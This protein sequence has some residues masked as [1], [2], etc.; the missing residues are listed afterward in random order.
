MK[1][2]LNRDYFYFQEELLKFDRGEYNDQV[3]SFAWLGQLINEMV[4][5]P[6]L[7]ELEELEYQRELKETQSIELIGRSKV[8]GY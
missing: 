5:A 7:K 2:P 6:S 4:E 8:T 1:Y 3:D